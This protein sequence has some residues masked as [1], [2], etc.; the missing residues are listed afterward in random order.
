VPVPAL[1][2]AAAAAGKA[3]SSAKSTPTTTVPVTAKPAPKPTP[4]R[5]P[6]ESLTDET[7]SLPSGGLT[8]GEEQYRYGC[9]Q[10]Y[11]TEGC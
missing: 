7:G 5:R 3:A 8:S 2:S 9:E 4:P 6:A 1:A 10:G 11:I